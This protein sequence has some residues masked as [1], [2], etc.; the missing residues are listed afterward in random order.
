MAGTW[1]LIAVLVLAPFLAWTPVPT[2]SADDE[3][4]VA[5]QKYLAH[6]YLNDSL[7]TVKRIYPPTRDW[8]SHREP[9]G[10]VTRIKVQGVSAKN[11]PDEVD[12]LWVGMRNDRVVEIQLVYDADYTSET[13]P[14]SLARELALVYGE[15][16]MSETGKFH[17]SDG[18]RVLRVFY[19]QVPV[20]KGKRKVVEMRT[21][22]QLLAADLVRR[23]GE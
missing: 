14:D 10:G 19:A 7:E 3:E 6:L 21:S 2:A 18:E 5:I 15:P 23:K 12:L 8:P 17:W 16:K 4:Q 13:T 22:M 11:F 20:L 1:T 9:K